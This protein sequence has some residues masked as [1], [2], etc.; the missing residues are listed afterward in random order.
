MARL[1]AHLVCASCTLFSPNT[2]NPSASTASILSSG[3]CL[4]TAISSIYDWSLSAFLA[5]IC[6]A[7]IIPPLT[8]PSFLIL[9]YHMILRRIFARPYHI[10][11]TT[12]NS[13]LPDRDITR[14]ACSRRCCKNVTNHKN[15]ILITN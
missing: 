7:L 2:R 15:V 14:Q 5:A 8:R 11:E 9:N 12:D 4:D 10:C 13:C 3:C 6:I 1:S